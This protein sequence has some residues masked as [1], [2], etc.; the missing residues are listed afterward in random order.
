MAIEERIPFGRNPEAQR[1]W[2]LLIEWWEY[3]T[4]YSI[5]RLSDSLSDW[6]LPPSITSIRAWPEG[7]EPISRWEGQS[8]ELTKIL[9]QRSVMFPASPLD[10]EW[11]WECLGHDEI[12]RR[13]SLIEK[14]KSAALE[15]QK[16]KYGIGGWTGKYWNEELRLL[17]SAI[18]VVSGFPNPYPV[19]PV[20]GD[21]NDQRIVR[22]RRRTAQDL[23]RLTLKDGRRMRDDEMT[24]LYLL[25]VPDGVGPG[26]ETPVEWWNFQDDWVLNDVE[27]FDVD[28]MIAFSAGY[29]TF[30][31][32]LRSWLEITPD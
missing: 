5:G 17:D 19:K 20:S 30:K 26:I 25:A 1:R 29:T 11:E 16:I 15:V 12:K 3:Q 7:G 31:R 18:A 4:T 8:P 23:S 13:H 28:G 14:L 9:C 27:D 6:V 32:R 21:R 22:M 10:D 24:V 2:N